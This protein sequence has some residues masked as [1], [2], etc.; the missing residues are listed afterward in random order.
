MVH[1]ASV[2]CTASDAALTV[3][4]VAGTHEQH[5]LFISCSVTAGRESRQ[6]AGVPAAV[7]VKD[8]TKT[9]S[10]VFIA[11]IWYVPQMEQEAAEHEL[12]PALTVT[13]SPTANAVVTPAVMSAVVKVLVAAEMA[14]A[15]TPLPPDAAFTACQL[16]VAS[17][18]GAG[19][20][21]R[22][23]HTPPRTDAQLA[24]VA[25][26]VIH[27]EAGAEVCP[28]VHA[29]SAVPSPSESLM[30]SVSVNRSVAVGWFA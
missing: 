20:Q 22:A 18:V 4:P 21:V 16:V 27:A 30:H 19:I 6:C 10:L 14:V 15:A 12:L 13:L 8:S 5:C 17:P 23:F 9:T 2:L 28:A 25:S 1:S 24:W 11:A 3:D 7:L 29:P 26:V